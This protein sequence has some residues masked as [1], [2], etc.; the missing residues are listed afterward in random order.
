M[1]IV[2]LFMMIAVMAFSKN[3]AV[4]ES[5]GDE[6]YNHK[7]G[8]ERLR[9]IKEFAKY[10]VTLD[11]YLLRLER[12][13]I[14]GFDIEYKRSNDRAG[15]LKLLR[16]LAKIDEHF[17]R[18][19]RRKFKD[20]LEKEDA[21]L[22]EALVNSG[23]IDREKNKQKI[24][25]FYYKHKEK[26]TLYP[27]TPLA[28]MILQEELRRK[29]KKKIRHSAAYYRKLRLEKERRKIKRVLQKDARKEKELQ[30]ALE[31][32]AELKKRAI[33]QKQLKALQGE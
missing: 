6:L 22:F 31:R 20:A 1:K 23:L 21:R 15:Y 9:E 24:L 8:L 32:E 5:L 7:Y 26:I 4:F 28:A 16:E 18:M 12:A 19:A 2:I 11:Q 33:R 14:K 27:D 3:P 25:D 30:E 13:K 17:V 29:P 10:R